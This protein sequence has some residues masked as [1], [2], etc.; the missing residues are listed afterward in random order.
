MDPTVQ[1]PTRTH[2]PATPVGA[3]S[4]KPRV[5]LAHDWLCGLRGGEHVLDAIAKLLARDFNVAGLFV[6]FDDGRP[7]TP[8]ID[9]LPKFVSNVG[10]WPAASTSMRRWLLPAYPAAVRALSRQLARLHAKT[11]IDLVISTSSAAIKGLAPPSGVPHLCYIH[12]P[13]RYIWS[14]TREYERGSPLR[15]LGLRMFRER[16]KRWDLATS[17]GVSRFIANS[18]HI[19]A[20]VRRCYGRDAFVVHPPVRTGFFTPPA[21]GAARGGWLVVSALEPYKRVDLAIEAANQTRSPLRIVGDGGERSGL[22]QIAGPTVR[23]LGRIDDAALR[24]EYQRAEMLLFPQVEDFGI[25]AVEAQACGCPVVAFAQGGALDTVIDQKSGAMFHSQTAADLISATRRCPRERG[26]ACRE[27]A[28][29]FSA[30]AFD[31][32]M[33]EHIRASLADER[34]RIGNAR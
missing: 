25:V 20:E 34:R 11:P 5:V 12:S 16:F 13:A 23:F 31:H 30:E 4:E 1:P 7:L 24:N 28:E 8:A 21:D 32:R 18:S 29:R 33:L 3:D 6:M 26:Q 19:A 2:E 10:T 14:R 15:T 17:A 9:A 22:E 27:N